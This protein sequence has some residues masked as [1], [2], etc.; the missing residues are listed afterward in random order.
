MFR[1]AA[2]FSLY[3]I[4]SP[5]YPH[6]DAQIVRDRAVHLEAAEPARDPVDA[7]GRGAA[8]DP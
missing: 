1:V 4:C 8:V 5:L 6:K 7:V 2:I 3:V